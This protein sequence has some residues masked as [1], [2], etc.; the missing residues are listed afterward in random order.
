V[1]RNVKVEIRQ[2]G[3]WLSTAPAL[4]CRS[5]GLASLEGPALIWGDGAGFESGSLALIWPIQMAIK[6]KIN[7]YFI[8]INMK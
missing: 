7:G 5:I 1:P 8:Y 2:L 3:S 4:L 6:A